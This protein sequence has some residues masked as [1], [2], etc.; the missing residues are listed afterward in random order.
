MRVSTAQKFKMLLGIVSQIAPYKPNMTKLAADIGVSKN[1]IQDYLLYMERAGMIAQLRDNTGGLRALGKVQKVFVD[2]PTL[3][4]ALSENEPN[5]G[6]LRE[7]FFFNQM[8]VRNK[9]YN[10]D[11]SDFCIGSYTFEVG[12]RKKGT[13]QIEGMADAYIVKDDIEYPAGNVIP[14][15]AFGLNY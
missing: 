9:V 11:V 7:T 2:N 10:S 8:R 6:N 12:G 3:M 1:N 14:L 5:I 15:W 4:Y 13:R